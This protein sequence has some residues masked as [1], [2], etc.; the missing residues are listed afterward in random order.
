MLVSCVPS[1]FRLFQTMLHVE[2]LSHY[3]HCIL[4]F[5]DSM[6][7]RPRIVV[8]FIVIPTLEGLVSEEVNGLVFHARDVLFLLN[9]LEAVCLVPAVREDVEGDL[10]A[11]RVA[12]RSIREVSVRIRSVLDIREP[13]V[14]ELRSQRLHHLGSYPM[15]QVV[16]VVLMPLIIARVSADRTHVHHSV[17]E[18]HEGTSLLRDVQVGDVMEAEVRELAVFLL[19]EPFDEGVGREGLAEAVGCEAVFREAEVEKRCYGDGRTAELFLLFC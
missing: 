13:V 6:P 3:P 10:A 14:G 8:D 11:N 2:D 4:R 12:K 15:L 16:L 1:T 17:P 18:L 19:A 7:S 9:L 5:G